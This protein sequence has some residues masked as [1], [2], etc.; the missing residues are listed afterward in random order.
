MPLSPRASTQI[1]IMTTF[2]FG[3][4]KKVGVMTA[5]EFSVMKQNTWWR[6]QMETFSALLAVCAGNSR[7]PVN[8]PHK[9]QWPG[10][11]MFSLICAW[12]NGWVNSGE[13]GDLRRHCAHYNVTV[14]R[15]QTVRQS[16]VMSRLP[17]QPDDVMTLKRSPHNQFVLRR[18]PLEWP[19]MKSRDVVM[20]NKLLNMSLKLPVILNTLTILW[21]HWNE[22]KALTHRCMTAP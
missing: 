8:S 7:W 6:H 16:M 9:G 21:S 20:L 1:V 18:I 13:A 10:A 19:V 17:E 2:N 11:L 5:L 22:W 14:M 12:I 4:D 15:K 3:R